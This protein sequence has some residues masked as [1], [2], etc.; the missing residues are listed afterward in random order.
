M[1]YT[2]LSMENCHAYGSSK[3]ISVGNGGGVFGRFPRDIHGHSIFTRIA[4]SRGFDPIRSVSHLAPD[5]VLDLERHLCATTNGNQV[6][7]N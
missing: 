4:I 1:L 3:T 2:T 5:A 7:S 6:G